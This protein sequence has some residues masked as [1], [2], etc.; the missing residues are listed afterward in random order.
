MALLGRAAGYPDFSSSGQGNYTPQIYAQKTLIKFYKSTFLSEICNTDYEGEIRSQGDKVIIRTV[1]D[2][3]IN[4]Y[5]IGQDIDYATYDSPSVVLEINKAKYY[6]FKIDNITALQTD[7]NLMDIWTTDAA[8]QLKIHIESAFLTDVF[9][10]NYATNV[11]AYNRGATAGAVSGSYALGVLGADTDLPIAAGATNGATCTNVVE[12]IMRAEA[13]LTEQ[14]V[15][16]D[17]GRWMIIPTWMGYK[18]QSSDLRRADSMGYPANQDVLRNG[19]IG[20]IGQFT[21]YISNN[22]PKDSY[23]TVIPFGHKSCLTFA[24]QMTE[25]ETLPHPLAFGKILRSLQVYGYKAIK[26]EGLGI[27]YGSSYAG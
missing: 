26:P 24:T 21:I 19:K 5:V 12:A 7:I 22:L 27:I 20:K 10:T 11:S 4:D 2:I 6:A 16:Q 23:G 17:E 3:T 9:L 18:L 1:P 8:E 13:A 14:N 25:T 15:P